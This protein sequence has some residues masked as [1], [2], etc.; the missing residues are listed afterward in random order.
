VLLARESFVHFNM[1]YVRCQYHLSV[2]PRAILSSVVTI[3]RLQSRQGKQ[4]QIEWGSRTVT[5]HLVRRKEG[6]GGGI[7]DFNQVPPLSERVAFRQVINARIAH[8]E[9]VNVIQLSHNQNWFCIMS[10]GYIASDMTN[11]TLGW[12]IG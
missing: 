6:G 9:D 11:R 4:E 1:L 8:A 12:C 5:S 3:Q 2:L 10:T 7:D